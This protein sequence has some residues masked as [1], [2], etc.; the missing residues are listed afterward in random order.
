MIGH[1]LNNSLA[2]IKSLAATLATLLTRE[3]RPPDWQEDMERGLSI[4]AARSESLIRFMEAYAR[5][6][7]LPKPRLSAMN[8][9]GWVHRAVSLETRVPIHF[10]NGA[11]VTLEADGDQME[12]LLT[13]LV[14]NAADAALETGGGA[15]IAWDAAD[16]WL[17]LRVEDEGPGLADSGNLFVPFYTTKPGGTG[18]G[19]TLCRQIAEAHGGT[20]TLVNR[21]NARGC[22][23]TVRLPLAAPRG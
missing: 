16:G 6:A 2:P 3:P 4:I 22:V 15:R 21:E 9:Q 10:A 12:T 23:A 8:V 5:L 11:E 7:R 14:R 18:I 19:L 20:V 13:N 1:E 17:T